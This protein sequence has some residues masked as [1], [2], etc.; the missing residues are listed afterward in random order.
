[1]ESHPSAPKVVPASCLAL[2]F[3]S[4]PM[5]QTP[6]SQ[7]SYRPWVNLGQQASQLPTSSLS[8]AQFNSH[9]D[10]TIGGQ[11]PSSAQGASASPLPGQAPSA[12]PLPRQGPSVSPL[13]AGA[14][15]SQS[16][17]APFRTVFPFKPKGTED[18]SERQTRAPAALRFF[19]LAELH[20]APD[21]AGWRCYLLTCSC[22]FRGV[23]QQV[24]EF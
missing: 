23:I 21:D 24:L 12:G 11:G 3:P 18:S 13:Q 9:S 7:Q 15:Q 2:A 17:K 22:T 8:R 20:Q 4:T 16:S 10:A 1:M 5:L 14:P 6:P 19:L